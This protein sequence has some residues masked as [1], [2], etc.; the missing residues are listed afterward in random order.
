VADTRHLVNR[1][2]Q[3][4]AQYRDNYKTPVPPKILADRLASYMQAYT[5]YGSVRPF[6]VS[7]VLGGLDPKGTPALYCLEPSGIFY[8]SPLNDRASSEGVKD[9]Y[10]DER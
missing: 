2:R 6:G 9:S 1:A 3:E 7:L 5:L 8:V 4:A 10:R